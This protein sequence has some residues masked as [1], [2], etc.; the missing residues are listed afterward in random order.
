MN[1]TSE[2]LSVPFS[3][4]QTF[5]LLPDFPKVGKLTL[6]DLGLFCAEKPFQDH[7]HLAQ[8]SVAIFKTIHF[9]CNF[10]WVQ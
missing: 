7:G 5:S 4:S 1:A 3:N 9:L 6:A 10:E 8:R 2:I